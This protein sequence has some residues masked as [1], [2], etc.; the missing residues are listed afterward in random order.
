MCSNLGVNRYPMWG[1]I[2]IGGA[3]EWYH[4]STK[5]Y[6]IVAFAHSSGKATNVR[7][8]NA[9]QVANIM[10]GGNGMFAITCPKMICLIIFL[11]D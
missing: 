9:E 5:L 7:A 10:E 6:D 8:L 4:G 2:K 3:F 1:I 11:L